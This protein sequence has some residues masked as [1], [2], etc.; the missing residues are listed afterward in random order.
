MGVE[1]SVQGLRRLRV[2]VRARDFAL[3]VYDQVLCL[4]PHHEKWNLGQQLRRSAVSI[5]A[6][7]AE[8]HGRYYYQDNVRFCYYARGSLD[9]TLS[10]LAFAFG[11]GMI[12]E[13]VYRR[14][15]TEGEVIEKML[16]AYIGYLKRSKRGASEP[17]AGAAS[18]EQSPSDR[19][20]RGQT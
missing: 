12:P 7:I 19:L 20:A 6:N 2:W 5:P 10:H 8:G 9:E 13:V 15:E 17:G 4:L 14:L 16:N 18:A 11:A 3:E 1:M